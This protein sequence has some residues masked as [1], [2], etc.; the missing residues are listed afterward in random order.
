[1]RVP[2]ATGCFALLASW[3]AAGC[4]GPLA[5]GYDPILDERVSVVDAKLESF[6]DSMERTG[7]TADGSFRG[8]SQFYSDVR[9]EL[10]ALRRRAVTSPRADLVKIFAELQDNVETLRRAHQSGGDRGLDRIIIEQL[11]GVIRTNFE[12]LYKRQASLRMG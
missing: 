1:M 8:N 12:I 7:G 6:L 9:G 3:L 5:A 2:L 11:R 10:E 4:A